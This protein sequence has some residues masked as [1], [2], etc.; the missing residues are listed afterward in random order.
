MLKADFK[1]TPQLVIKTKR[2]LNK[3]KREILK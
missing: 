2:N 1:H 3:E